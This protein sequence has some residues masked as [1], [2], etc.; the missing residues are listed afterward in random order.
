MEISPERGASL[1][2]R[3]PLR[4]VRVA[5]FPEVRQSLS[6]N[7]QAQAGL[8]RLHLKTVWG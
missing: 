8:R 2:H 4:S 5:D 7:L 3:F 1:P 6:R